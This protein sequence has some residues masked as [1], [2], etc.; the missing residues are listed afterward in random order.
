MKV[1]RSQL[2]ELV[3][4]SI[5]NTISEDDSDKYTHIG[6][7]RYKKKGQEKKKD[8]PTFKKDDSGKFT[9]S[10]GDVGGPAHPNVPMKEK[11]KRKRKKLHKL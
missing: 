3:R 1:T 4:Q 6:Y 11:P 7:G 2:K 5:Y 8:A 9:P 10:G